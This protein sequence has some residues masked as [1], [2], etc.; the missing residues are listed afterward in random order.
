MHKIIILLL[1]ITAISAKTNLASTIIDFDVKQPF[2]ENNL[3]FTF[4]NSALESKFFLVKIDS[5]LFHVKYSYQCQIPGNKSESSLNHLFII[6]A[7]PGDCRINIEYALKELT[8]KGTIWVHPFDRE[9]IFNLEKEEKF[10]FSKY[11][12]FKE[13][14]PSLFFSVS[15]LTKDTEVKFTHGHDVITKGDKIFTLKN[16]FRICQGKECKDDI[17]QYTFINETDYT[18]EIKTEEINAGT[19]KYYYMNSFSFYKKSN[20]GNNILMNPLI[21]LVLL[22][23]LSN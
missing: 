9:I 11:V 4:T 8:S 15:N 12:E 16:P 13:K 22:L 2:D 19:K 23:L 3:I 17:S 21:Y 14:F 1:L 6:K 18:I 20:G 7:D 10:A 5:E